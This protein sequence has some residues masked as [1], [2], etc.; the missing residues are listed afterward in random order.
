MVVSS[1]HGTVPFS[2]SSSIWGS[3]VDILERA[4]LHFSDS[5]IWSNMKKISQ[6]SHLCSWHV[7][8]GHMSICQFTGCD[9]K[10]IDV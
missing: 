5:N 2:F 10:T 9:A 1:K 8:E 6:R 7:L 3:N 4:R